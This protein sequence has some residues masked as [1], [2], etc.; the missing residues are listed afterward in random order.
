MTHSQPFGQLDFSSNM[1]CSGEGGGGRALDPGSLASVRLRQFPTSAF[2]SSEEE[3]GLR[4]HAR[5]HPPRG[6]AATAGAGWG[7]EKGIPTCRTLG[8]LWSG[9]SRRLWMVKGAGPLELRGGVGVRRVRKGVSSVRER[10]RSSK[11]RTLRPSGLRSGDGALR[12]PCATGPM[13]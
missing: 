13:S 11:L 10:C 8:V 9:S 5:N 7:E 2:P 6:G 1:R 4:A 3:T 12:P